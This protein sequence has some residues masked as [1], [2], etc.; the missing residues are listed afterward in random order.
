MNQLTHYNTNFTNR[1]FPIT[2]IADNVT[3]PGNI[4]SLLRLSD[5]FGI[6]KL[7]LCGKDI[8]ISRK[9]LRTSRATEKTVDYDILE[10]V[11]PV[12]KE[13]KKSNHQ[14]IALEITKNSHSLQTFHIQQDQPIVL[15]VGSENFGISEPIIEICD[16]CI[17]IDMFGQNSSMNVAQAANIALYEMTKQLM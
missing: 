3:S 9:A 11:F 7:I 15:I 13:Y 10:D 1:T 8:V 6:Q 4:G 16:F 12:L 5:A 2:L 14:L 17:H